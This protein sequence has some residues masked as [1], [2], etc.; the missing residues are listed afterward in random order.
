MKKNEI[1]DL[2]IEDI[3]NLGFGVAKCSGIV[4][5]VADTVPGDYVRCKVI[6]TASSYVVARVEEYLERSCERAVR[7]ENK[8]CKSC[9][10]KN[11]SYEYEKSIKEKSV[12]QDFLKAGLKE[13]EVMPLVA[14]PSELFYRNKAQYPVASDGK[15]GYRI[16]FFAPKSHRVTEAADCALAPAIFGEIIEELRIFFTRHSLTVYDEERGEGLLR[17][18]Y[19]RRGEVSGEVLLTLVINGE[20]IPAQEELV[21]GMTKRFPE[22]VGILLNINKESTNVILGDRYLTL[23]GRDYI[24]DTLA[25]VRLKITA[26]S[27]YQVNHDAAELLY[28]KARE[29]ARPTKAD[30]LLDLYCGAGSI[31]LSM[32]RDVG[33]LVG[34]EIVDSA[35]L[36][37]R[38]NARDNGIENASFFTG[39]AKYTERMLENAESELGRKIEPT[40]IIL[41]PPRAGCAAELVKYVASLNPQRIVYISCNPTTL[42]RDVKL[43]FELGYFCNSVTPFDL[44]PMTGHVESVVCLTRAF[45]N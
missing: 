15:G 44:F 8:L 23:Y 13:V 5:F 6:K 41:D 17:H 20:G 43:F 7:C 39:D 11:I 32:A 25:G 42:A 10:Y 30:V 24:Y 40:I 35:V 31:G 26:P 33:E 22:I 36:C 4:A 3:T 9:A 38:E 27:F 29:L 45:D 34:I 1:I 21:G 16:G 28:A 12:R 18:I 14:S 2:R 37:A 19:L